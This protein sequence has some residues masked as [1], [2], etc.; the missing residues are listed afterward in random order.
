M[1]VRFNQKNGRFFF[2]DECHLMW[3]DVCGYVWGPQSDRV[4]I[5]IVNERKRQ[6][7]FGALNLFTGRATIRKYDRANSESTIRFLK[8]L[9]RANQRCKLTIFW[10]GVGYH[11]SKLVKSFLEK[12]N[13][14]KTGLKAKLNLVQ[15]APNAPEENPIEDV[16]LSGKSY[17]RRQVNYNDFSEIQ[18]DFEKSVTNRKY[19][20][21][22]IDRYKS[23]YE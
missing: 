8:D 20:F 15:L 23:Y 22:K 17:I 9:L 2:E 4:K 7:Y 6:S 21:N 19:K 11:R 14:G 1:V 16:W 3:G 10:D 18:F 13:K 12:I 5:P